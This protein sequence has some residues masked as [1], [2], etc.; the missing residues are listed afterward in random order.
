MKIQYNKDKQFFEK[1]NKADTP[2]TRLRKKN[3]LR[4]KQV[5]LMW[6]KLTDINVDRKKKTQKNTK[7]SKIYK[8]IYYLCTNAYV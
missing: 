5:I 8:T 3:R 1:T 7:S 6:E 4:H 2:L